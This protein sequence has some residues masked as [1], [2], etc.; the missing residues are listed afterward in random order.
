MPFDPLD[1]LDAF[2]GPLP[3]PSAADAL[4]SLDEDAKA[5]LRAL[6][7]RI[8]THEEGMA[9]VAAA[10]RDVYAQAK[11][12]GLDPETIRWVVRIRAM[13][14]GRY[15][16]EEALRRLYLDAVEP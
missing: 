14:P 12:H 9:E 7:R 15:D 11:A 2:A 3:A 5:R 8:E 1:A 6:V 16:D 10:I 4:P 13:Q